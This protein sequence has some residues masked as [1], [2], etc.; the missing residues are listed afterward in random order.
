MLLTLNFTLF[1]SKYLAPTYLSGLRLNIT[2][3]EPSLVTPPKVG[4]PI[5]FYLYPTSVISFRVLIFWFW[6]VCHCYLQ[7]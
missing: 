7:G 6:F 5:L 1:P 3:S 2:P 4:S